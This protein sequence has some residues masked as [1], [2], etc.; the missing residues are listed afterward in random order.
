M[1]VFQ[2]AMALIA[3]SLTASADP[4]PAFKVGM[5]LDKGGKDDKSF[6]HAAYEGLTRAKKELK[7][8]GKFVEAT[9][10]NA[11]EPM[12]RAFA[13]KDFDLIIGI[14]VS[15]ADAIR[16]VSKQ[17][18]NKKFAIVDAEVP[19]P[20]VRSL[21]F[22]E[23]EGS[24]LVGALAAMSTK[25]GK[26]GFIGGMDIP[27]IRRFQMGYEAGA[28]SVKP[29]V[30]IFVNYVGVSSEAWNNPAKAK[31]LAVSQY[32]SG[33]DVI[34][35]AAGAS[36][37]GLFDAAEEDKKLAIGCDSNQNW[38]KP[39]FVLTSMMKRV[40]TAIYDVIAETNAGKFTAGVKRYG[41][42]NRGI[43]YAMD[44]YNDKLVPVSARTRLE[45]LKAQIMAG[46]IVVPDYYKKK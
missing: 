33:V 11:F 38:V 44:E 7:I 42:S 13:R 20:N 12:L 39:G 21:L 36:G 5:V 17:F 34:F 31:E 35:G 4:A 41:L 10:D 25:S 32:G 1:R 3:F 9:D 30:R 40:D 24:F 2:L 27:L 8:S 45:K 18:P 14:G 23:H 28:R 37:N 26:V 22:E 16:K 15:Q 29:N 46:K 19:N 43:D 6:N